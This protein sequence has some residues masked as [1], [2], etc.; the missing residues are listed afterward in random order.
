MAT[1]VRS[2]QAYFPD[3]YN[4]WYKEAIEAE[5]RMKDKGTWPKRFD[6]K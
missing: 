4:E 6:K 5:R 1:N 2:W 3:T